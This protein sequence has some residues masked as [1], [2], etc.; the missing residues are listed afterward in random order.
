MNY[1][2]RKDSNILIHKNGK[3]CTLT[4]PNNIKVFYN[5]CHKNNIYFKSSNTIRGKEANI[6][7]KYFDLYRINRNNKKLKIIPENINIFIERIKLIKEKTIKGKIIKYNSFYINSIIEE[8]PEYN[9]VIEDNI[10]ED[11]VINYDSDFIIEIA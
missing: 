6:I 8:L 5:I 4:N 2:E 11:T 1:I 10:S 7:I 3:V 9:E